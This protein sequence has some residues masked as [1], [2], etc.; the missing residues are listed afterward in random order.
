MKIQLKLMIIN[1]TNINK[2]NNHFPSELN[3]L[4]TKKIMT[5]DVGNPVL[6]L[7]QAQKCGSVKLVRSVIGCQ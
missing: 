1:S 3:S 6:V 5:Y 2:T 4:N 7:G